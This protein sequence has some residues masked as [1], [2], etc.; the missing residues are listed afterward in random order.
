M[1]LAGRLADLLGAAYVP[2]GEVSAQA[3]VTVAGGTAG[4]M[5]GGAA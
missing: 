4:R 1:G 3:L 2:L 5:T